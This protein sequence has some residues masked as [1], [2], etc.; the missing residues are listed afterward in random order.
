MAKLRSEQ[1]SSD[2]LVGFLWPLL[3]VV[4]PPTSPLEGVDPMEWGF[5]CM[6]YDKKRVAVSSSYY[7]Y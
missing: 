3:L 5:L 1:A 6:E 4:V 7:Y 2:N